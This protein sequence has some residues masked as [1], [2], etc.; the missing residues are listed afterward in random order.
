[1]VPPAMFTVRDQK[2]Q[3]KFCSRSGANDADQVT[4]GLYRGR[5]VEGRRDIPP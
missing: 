3:R 4:G 5:P 2:Y 1:M